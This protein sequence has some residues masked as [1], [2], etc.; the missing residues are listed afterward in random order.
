MELIRTDRRR[1]ARQASAH[2]GSSYTAVGVRAHAG[3]RALAEN[4][5]MGTIPLHRRCAVCAAQWIIVTASTRP[6]R[7]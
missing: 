1:P 5:A 2:A 7:V 6:Q 4:Q 3:T